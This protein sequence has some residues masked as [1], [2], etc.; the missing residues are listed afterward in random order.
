[1]MDRVCSQAF[2]P[3][4]AELSSELV[5]L[6]IVIGKDQI[7]VTGLDETPYKLVTAG[8][9][10]VLPRGCDGGTLI[11]WLILVRTLD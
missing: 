8:S 5:K 2:T 3:S 7:V 11:T 9:R 1:M 4:N 6:A 10:W